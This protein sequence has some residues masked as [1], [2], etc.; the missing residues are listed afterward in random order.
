MARSE[1]RP[2]TARQQAMAA[3]RGRVAERRGLPEPAAPAPLAALLAAIRACRI[4]RDTPDGVALPHE[5]RQIF[6]LSATARVA[7]CSQAPGNRAHIA[8]KPFHDPSGVR[9]RDWM[10]L[11]EARFYDDSRVAIVPMGFCFPGYDA[12]GGDLPPRRECRARWHDALFASLPQVELFLLIGRHSLDYH[13]PWTTRLPLTEIVRD[14]RGI[15][16]RTAP[17]ARIALPH[18]SWRNNAWLAKNPWFAAEL[19]PDLRARVAALVH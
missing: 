4:C 12:A 15:A 8:G 17:H 3:A 14:W 7:I 16:A 2:P 19:L 11:D 9:L 10:G 5:P 18:P 6:Q 1:P 13:L